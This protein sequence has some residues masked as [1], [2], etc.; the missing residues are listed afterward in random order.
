M[1]NILFLGDSITDSEHLFTADNLGHGYV[2]LLSHALSPA[3]YT[4]CNRGHD[5]FTTEQIWRMLLRDGIE[6]KWDVITLLTGV[7]DIPVEVYTTHNRIP[8]E[9]M[10]YY[11]KLLQLFTSAT[12]AKIILLEPFLFDNPEEYKNWHSYIYTE[13]AI[14]QELAKKYHAHFTPT[15]DILRAAAEKE[16]MDRITP[17]G[18]HLTSAGNRILAGLWLKAL[19]F[20]S[21]PALPA[22]FL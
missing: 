9:F 13:S 20:P 11:E 8:D 21:S 2:S 12:H 18:I 7:N 17:D 1:K 10:Y 5:G 16:G 6:D 4:V 15:D 3:E 22:S 14:I 19:D